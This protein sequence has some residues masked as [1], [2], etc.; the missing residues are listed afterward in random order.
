MILQLLQHAQALGDFRSLNNKKR[1]VL[2]IHI[3]GELEKGLKTLINL[4]R[5]VRYLILR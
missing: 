1:R 2:R 5:I 4:L 3:S